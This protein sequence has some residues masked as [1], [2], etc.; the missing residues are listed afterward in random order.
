M[1]LSLN[2]HCPGGE[3]GRRATLRSLW[4]QPLAGSTPVLGTFYFS[5]RKR[6]RLY[7][8]AEQLELVHSADKELQCKS[9]SGWA[10]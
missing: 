6:F 8:P 2:E 4:G 5:C 1:E 3:I 9:H 7:L 10:Y